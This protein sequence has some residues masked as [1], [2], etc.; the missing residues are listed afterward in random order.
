MKQKVEQI[1]INYESGPAEA[2]ESCR[3]YCQALVHQQGRH[4]KAIAADMDLSPSHLSRK[5]AQSPDDSMRFT[6]DDFERFITVN[7]DVRPI[8]YLVEKYI[9]TPDTEALKREIERLQKQLEGMK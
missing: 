7:K 1:S 2:Y 4:Q 9:A 5:L 3:E 8:L 6:L